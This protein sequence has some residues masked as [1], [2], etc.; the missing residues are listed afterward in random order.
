MSDTEPGPAGE[1]VEGRDIGSGVSLIRERTDVVGSG[2]RLHRHPYRE[3]FV[4]Q[5]GRALFT[6]GDEQREGRA[7]DVL[8]VPA[9]T[10]HRFRV[11]GPGTYEAVHIHENDHFVTEWLD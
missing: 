3:T 7:G 6:I 4:I 5:R 9:G 1:S 10:P 2:P 11:L 8:V